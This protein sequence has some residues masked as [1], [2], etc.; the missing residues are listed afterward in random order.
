[1]LNWKKK[2]LHQKH[3]R[4]WNRQ[5]IVV[6]ELLVHFQKT[7]SR[8]ARNGTQHNITRDLVLL[9]SSSTPHTEVLPL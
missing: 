6:D 2:H 4:N 8:D 7:E 9:L 5:L 3:P 1:V